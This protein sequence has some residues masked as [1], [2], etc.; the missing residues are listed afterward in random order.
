MTTPGIGAS[1]ILGVAFEILSPL[2]AVA[3]AP[4]VGGALTAGVYKY[5]VTKVTA[6]GETTISNEVTVTTAS[7]NLTAALTWVNDP[8][9]TSY[10]VYRTA[11]AGATGT[12]LLR[13]SAPAGSTGYNDVA[14]GTPAGALPTANTAFASGSYTAP[15][16]FIPYISEGLQFQQDT[17]WRR[18]LRNTP[19]LVGAVA[20]N[21]HTEGDV[22]IEALSDCVP[23]FMY[24]SRCT[25]VKTGSAPY[26]Y[27]FTPA[28]I[29]VP[30]R[31]LSITVVRN[32]VTF[33][34]TG[35]T[36]QDFKYTVG[37]DGELQFTA[38]II[39]FDEA[40]QT[41]P[42][43]TWPTSVPFG[44]G[45]YSLQIPTAT[46]VFDADGFEFESNDNGAANWRMDN[47]RGANFINFG[48]SDATLTLMRDFLSR[49]EYDAFKTLTS[50][51][52]TLLVTRAAGDGFT[53]LMP[54]A[55]KNTYEVN[56]GAQGDIVRASITYECA[57]DG[58]G[59]HYQV[60]I[61]ALTENIS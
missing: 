27:T 21:S 56:E 39:G 22:V 10:N 31:T 54:V 11:A 60:A 42:T 19:G 38:S 29:A 52:V 5:Y 6:Q 23:Y 34:Y 3:G 18:P 32:G 46:Q 13:A 44:P 57:I 2:V 50:Q 17:I 41:L 20:G 40:S 37:D 45:N 33:G 4:A 1:S 35:C 30:N 9:A 28:P 59:K 12:E 61:V 26:T 24:A 43:A 51:S 48:E 8:F 7:G 58:T 25:C 16:K 15:T 49:T 36:V 47:N 55:F 14:V 53:I